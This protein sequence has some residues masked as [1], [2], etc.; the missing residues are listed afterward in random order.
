MVVVSNATARRYDEQLDR[1]TEAI[2]GMLARVESER[3]QTDAEALIV[4]LRLDLIDACDIS[5]DQ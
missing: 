5:P 2:E 3:M 4:C 1:D